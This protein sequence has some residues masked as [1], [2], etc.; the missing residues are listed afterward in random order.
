MM[1]GGGTDVL[2][3]CFT[4][5]TLKSPLHGDQAGSRWGRLV[6][7][8]HQNPNATMLMLTAQSEL[9]IRSAQ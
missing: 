3:M 5:T 9:Q 8:L 2:E 1:H 6:K 7:A 4:T